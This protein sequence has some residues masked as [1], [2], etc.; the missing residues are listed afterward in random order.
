MAAHKSE[1]SWQLAI[2]QQAGR[3]VAGLQINPISLTQNSLLQKQS[4]KYPG[5]HLITTRLY[6]AELL[7]ASSKANAESQAKTRNQKEI[8]ADTTSQQTGGA[9]S[10]LASF[11]KYAKQKAI[12]AFT[13]LRS[14][15]SESSRVAA[16]SIYS[17]PFTQPSLLAHFYS[18][19]MRTILKAESHRQ[20]RDRR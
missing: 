15:D 7:Q 12:Q 4:R 6:V 20:R 11:R 8:A 16:C 3:V 18:D 19:G 1:E 13:S 9:V 14:D 2:R 5:F 10:R 17:G